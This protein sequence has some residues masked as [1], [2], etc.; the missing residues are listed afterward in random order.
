MA[1]STRSDPALARPRVRSSTRA[2]SWSRNS[3]SSIPTTETRRPGFDPELVEE[4]G[5]VPD[6]LRPARGLVAEVEHGLAFR[7]IPGRA[8]PRARPRCCRSLIA[9]LNRKSPS[10]RK[11]R[12]VSSRRAVA[13]RRSACPSVPGRPLR[14]P[15]PRILSKSRLRGCGRCGG[16]CRGTRTGRRPCTRA[17][18]RSRAGGSGRTPRAPPLPSAPS[19]PASAACPR[20]RPDSRKRSSTQSG[21]R[22]AV[23]RWASA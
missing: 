20:L 15:W 9:T 3:R 8:R 11:T 23:R 16:R 4:R 2:E 18:P 5:R 14:V 6:L 17:A 22:P 19:P 21:R 7:A 10:P 12:S 1:T 13:G